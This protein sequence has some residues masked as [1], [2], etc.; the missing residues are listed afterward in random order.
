MTMYI[1]NVN[2]WLITGIFLFFVILCAAV[3]NVD[4]NN[5]YGI[6]W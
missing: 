5:D 4:L 3:W 6:K 1:C 2:N